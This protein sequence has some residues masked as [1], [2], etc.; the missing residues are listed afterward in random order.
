MKAHYM[1]CLIRHLTLGALALLVALGANAQSVEEVRAGLAARKK[2]L[3]AYSAKVFE[4]TT[5]LGD[6]SDIHYDY[7]WSGNRH[8]LRKVASATEPEYVAFSDGSKILNLIRDQ[9]AEKW[10]GV[11]SLTPNGP[12]QVLLGMLDGSANHCDKPLADVLDG[13]D[14]TVTDLHVTNDFGRQILITGSTTN[15]NFELVLAPE[16]DWLCV[17][18]DWTNLEGT[19]KELT[20]VGQIEKVNG[21]WVPTVVTQKAMLR[22]DNKWKTTYEAARTASSVSV[23][24]CEPERFNVGSLFG[25]A[26]VVESG[27]SNQYRITPAGQLEKIE[28][29]PASKQPL[30]QVLLAWIG[31]MAVCVMPSIWLTRWN[32]GRKR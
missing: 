28:N 18:S 31:I 17:S 23:G 3:P 8:I 30:P 15:R 11:F 2:Q 4:H 9:K 26:I 5:Q 20:S 14:F 21:V 7:Y 19:S 16:R 10:S 13:F 1:K 32:L 12:A 6:I 27:T 24:Q 22:Q 25:G 29:A